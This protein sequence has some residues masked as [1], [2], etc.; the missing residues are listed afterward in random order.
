MGKGHSDELYT[1][2]YAFDILSQY[3]P[4]DKTIF[5]CAEGTGQLKSIMVADG[6]NVIGSK[7]FFNDGRKDFD[8]I[9]SNPPYSLK[10]AFIERCYQIGKPFALLMPINAFEGKK[11]QEYYKKFGIQVLLP[12][13]RIDF[14]GKGSPWFY[15][16]WFCWKILPKDIMF[17][18][19]EG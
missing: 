19:K 9:V 7:D 2:K 6:F 8:I 5:E 17:T 1:P 16:A 18:D 11:R 10:D 4:K 3:L 14:N 13:K 12:D 15:T